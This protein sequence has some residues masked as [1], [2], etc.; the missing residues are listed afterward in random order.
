MN[1]MSMLCVSLMLA[2]SLPVS[3]ASSSAAAGA[4]TQRKAC[5]Q[6]VSALVAGEPREHLLESP[7]GLCFALGG[8]DRLVMTD[9]GEEWVLSKSADGSVMYVTPKKTAGAQGMTVYRTDGKAVQFHLVPRAAASGAARG[10][11]S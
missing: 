7:R 3:A 4:R 5:A 6:D 1:K 2:S 9:E 11:N 10:T 8:V